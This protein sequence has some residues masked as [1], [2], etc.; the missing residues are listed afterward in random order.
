MEPVPMAGICV[1]RNRSKIE[2]QFNLIIACSFCEEEQGGINEPR[3][4]LCS[5]CRYRDQVIE[6][7]L[8]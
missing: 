2:S 5:L 7:V 4:G 1:W 3:G 8:P 6:L